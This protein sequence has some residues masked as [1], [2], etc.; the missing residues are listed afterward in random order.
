MQL[1][2]APVRTDQTITVQERATTTD[3]YVTLVENTDY[4]VDSKTDSIYRINRNFAGGFGAVKVVYKAGYSATPTD[5]KLALID[6]ITYYHKDEHKQRQTLGGA[7]LQNQGTSSQRDNP[8]F[9]DHI[10]RVL[11]MYKN[12]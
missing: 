11:D 8:G 4:Y 1:S 12:F 7:S 2:E 6:L 9:P 3:S 10:K 5:L